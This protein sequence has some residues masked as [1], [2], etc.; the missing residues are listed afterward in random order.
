MIVITFFKNI[1]LA[2]ANNIYAVYSILK[3]SDLRK[4]AGISLV[5]HFLLYMLLTEGKKLKF[6]NKIYKDT[7]ME[8]MVYGNIDKYRPETFKRIANEVNENEPTISSTGKTNNTTRTAAVSNDK[9]L[10]EKYENDNIDIGSD[11]FDKGVTRDFSIINTSR[12]VKLAFTRK[13]D[14]LISG[15]TDDGSSEMIRLAGCEFRIVLGDFDR[16]GHPAYVDISEVLVNNGNLTPLLRKTLKRRIKKLTFN[17][18]NKQKKY[19]LK[20]RIVK[21]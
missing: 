3:E 21:I 15:A 20:L 19:I 16:Y 9:K 7:Y 17:V 11:V 12:A 1:G 13:K 6:Y 10:L 5:I 8:V 2:I 18:S 14:I 4:A